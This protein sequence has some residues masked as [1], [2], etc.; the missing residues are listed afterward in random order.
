MVNVLVTDTSADA[1]TVV[2]SLGLQRACVPPEAGQVVSPPPLARAV[3]VTLGAAAAP[4]ATVKVIG[5]PVAPAAI[6][7]VL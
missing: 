4:T 6:A 1:V 7:V 3:L 2:G 5:E